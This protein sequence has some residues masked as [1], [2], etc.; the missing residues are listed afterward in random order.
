MQLG[1]SLILWLVR[2]RHRML[3]VSH[4]AIQVGD[5]VWVVSIVPALAIPLGGCVSLLE[6][7]LILRLFHPPLT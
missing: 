4:S 7:A 1:Q 2:Q 5:A 6:L 3:L